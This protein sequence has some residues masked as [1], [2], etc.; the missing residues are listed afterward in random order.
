VKRDL[1]TLAQILERI[2]RI[3]ASG[4]DRERFSR[5]EWDQD[6]VIRN[7][8]VIGEAVK[9]LSSGA[10]ARPSAARWSEFTGLRD[11]AIHGYDVVNL[12]RTWAVVE[13]DLPLLKA[14]VR[15]L[16]RSLE[17]ER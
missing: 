16:M 1:T 13:R 12:D 11:V 15:K 7:L 10:R 8:E 6:A 14:E 5:N 4:V 3:E 17:S 9:R 2:D